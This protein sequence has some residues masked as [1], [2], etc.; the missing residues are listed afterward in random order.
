LAALLIVFS[1]ENLQTAAAD[2]DTRTLTMHHMHTGEDISITFKRNGQYDDAALQKL[3][4]FLRD[5]RREESTK[6]DPHLLDLIWEV[7][8]EVGGQ[9]PIQIVCGFRAPQTNAM[10]R[11]R[12][13]GVARFSQHTLGKAIDF[14]IPGVGL[15]QIRYAGLRM[16][17]GGVGFYPT[18][19]SPFIHLDTGSVRHWPRMS[20]EQLARVLSTRTKFAHDKRPAGYQ[21]ALAEIERRNADAGDE[22][23][24]AQHSKRG[25][26]Q[27]LFGFGEDEDEEV[28]AATP[29]AAK[30]TGAAA[31]TAARSE[32]AKSEPAKQQL[33]AAVPLPPGRPPRPNQPTKPAQAARP[34]PAQYSLA[35]LESAP[36]P[37]PAD[38][39]RSRGMWETATP[40]TEA[41]ATPSAATA[42]PATP[43][44]A[45]GDV[46]APPP[47][48]PAGG[49]R[50]VWLTGP[51][52]RPVEPAPT[53]TAAAEPPRPPA[54]IPNV[55]QDT[56]ASLASWTDRADRAPGPT[57][58]YAA[59]PPRDLEVEGSAPLAGTSARL[60]PPPAAGA[61]RSLASSAALANAN[62]PGQRSDNP[63][64]RGLVI[65][66]S[67]HYSMSVAA[68][69]APD[70]R[71]IARL[72]QKPSSVLAMTFSADPQ[73]GITSYSFSGSAVAF[74]PTVSFTRTAAL[75]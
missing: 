53:R 38:I 22:Q 52:G 60:T 64:L 21:T 70:Y 35:S 8:R 15:E 26:I 57:L 59:P 42:P 43:S 40:A 71:Q 45:A 2:G 65:A 51:Q 23:P 28:A 46:K 37:S 67:V 54:E 36:A 7:Y 6:M 61:T 56:T 9:Q 49:Q 44:T 16:Q 14:Y 25:L 20:N 12:S 39:V 31:R 3:N 50:F 74:L 72:M 66:P 58:A 55:D 73:A 69:G 47:G 27:R 18:S 75:N 30:P 1:S 29:S 24:V 63:W 13:S 33:A 48:A 62:R 4:N 19:G 68:F 10:L 32:P 5:W 41:P 11:R 34:A 17:R